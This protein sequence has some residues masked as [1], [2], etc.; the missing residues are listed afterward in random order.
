M[1]EKERRRRQ[2]RAYDAELDGQI[3]Q[4]SRV[5]LPTQ[6]DSR[7]LCGL[8]S[9]QVCLYQFI[10]R[11]GLTPAGALRALLTAKCRLQHQRAI[12]N[13]IL[14]PLTSCPTREYPMLRKQWE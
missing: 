7:R 14:L 1:W 10:Q 6:G 9:R 4:P 5:N 3:W 8:R 11:G 2:W 12:V 13:H